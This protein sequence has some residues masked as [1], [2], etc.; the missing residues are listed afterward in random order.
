MN[1][2]FLTILSLLLILSLAACG[3][4]SASALAAETE[5]PA[6]EIAEEQAA[7]V[8][9]AP[10]A[11]ESEP[12]ENTAP[13]EEAE[14][15]L[16]VYFSSANTTGPD[17]V[18]GAT[19]RVDEA[20][21]TVLL[22]QYVHDRVGGDIAPII[23]VED[24]P[25]DYDA[26][27]D[28]AKEEQDN[29]ARPAFTLDVDPEEYDTIFIGYPIWWYRLPMI[30]NTFFEAYDFSGK[31]I[32][33]F[34]THAGSRDGGTYSV[35]AELEPNATVLDGLAVSGETVEDAEADAATWLAALGY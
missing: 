26:T 9:A 3:A 29:D 18:S 25:E 19:P 20:G 17:V 11:E 23:V 13:V 8:T 16:V 1:K 32:I 14:R 6:E 27:A 2:A 15:I 34:N 10:V 35:I 28:Q 5:A 21:A 30:M 24:Y 22:A 4:S 33:P 7:E 12:E 31:T